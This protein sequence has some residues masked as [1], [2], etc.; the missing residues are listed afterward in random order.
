M[1]KKLVETAHLQSHRMKHKKKMSKS[2]QT[3]IFESIGIMIVCTVCKKPIKLE[4]FEEHV[5]CHQS[6]S[7]QNHKAQ[8]KITQNFQGKSIFTEQKSKYLPKYRYVYKCRAC[9]ILK[10]KQF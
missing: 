3:N 9:Q 10:G 6:K 1:C 5:K 8:I 2:K 4:D 7:L